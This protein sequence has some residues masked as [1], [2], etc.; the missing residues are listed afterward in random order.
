MS[1]V[2]EDFFSANSHGSSVTLSAITQ[3]QPP[4]A[5]FFAMT[6][7]GV[8]YLYTRDENL[9]GKKPYTQGYEL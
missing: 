7:T 6:L 3:Q 8:C 4:V 9:A 1:G 5:A 2:R